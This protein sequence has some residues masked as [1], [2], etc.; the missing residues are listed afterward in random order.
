MRVIHDSDTGDFADE[1]GDILTLLVAP[2]KRDVDACAKIEQE[3]GEAQLARLKEMGFTA[4]SALK[5][6]EKADP[7]TL[8]K[9]REAVDTRIT[10]SPKVREHRLKALAVRL[11]IGGQSTGGNAIFDTYQSM[12][13]ESAA[14]V[15]ARVA[16]VWKSAMP[17]EADTRSQAADDDGP[18]EPAVSPAAECPESVAEDSDDARPL[19]PVPDAEHAA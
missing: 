15:D 6:A 13:P 18:D 12:D 16:E 7:K 9:A 10:A 17:S 1:N 2:R 5:T 3:E 14:W 11:V 4:E 19:Q 8:A